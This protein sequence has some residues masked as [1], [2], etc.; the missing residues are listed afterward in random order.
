MT[1]TRLL[2]AVAALTLGL[3][4]P[5]LSAATT[6]TAYFA[7]GC[8]WT[9]ETKF[10]K[11]PGVTDAQSG[12]AGPKGRPSYENHNG[13]LEAVKVT[14]DP[15]KISYRKLVDYYWRMIDPTD[16]QGQVCDLGP[17][18]K[19]AIFVANAGERTAAEASKAAIDDGKRMTRIATKILPAAT[20]YPAEGYHQDYAKKNPGDYEAY[21][22]GCG[23]DVILARVWA[24]KPALPG[25][26]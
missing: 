16:C 3:A 10:D 14:Y 7:G 24:D 20:F 5:A 22:V 18:Y 23:R 9:V 21:R 13:Y 11:V 12:Y 26:H 8:F 19:T 2:A 15:S 17:S 6:A 1:R 4:A 25:K